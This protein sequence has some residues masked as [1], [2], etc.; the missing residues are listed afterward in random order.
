MSFLWRAELWGI[1]F[2][3]G[4]VVV[5]VLL[6]VAHLELLGP[7]LPRSVLVPKEQF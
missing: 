6:I 5:G 3:M 1:V 7:L 4:P 2:A